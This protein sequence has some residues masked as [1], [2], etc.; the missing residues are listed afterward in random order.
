MAYDKK[1]QGP[2]PGCLI[3][4]IDQSASMEEP[5]GGTQVGGGMKKC[6][7]VA[8]VLNRL[9]NGFILQNTAGGV[10]KSRVDV[11]VLGY[12]ADQIKSALAGSLAGKDFVS[13]PE[14]HDNP[15]GT[16]IIMKKEVDETGNLFEIPINI[17]KWVE[18]I[19]D[20]STP[21]KAA[22][23][24][25]RDLADQWTRNH[26]ESYPPVVINITDG[27]ATDVVD[28]SNPVELFSAAD[29]IKAVQTADGSTLMYTCHLTDR[30]YRSVEFPGSESDLPDDPFA[31]VLYKLTSEVPQSGHVV[32]EN[33]AGTKLPSSARGFIFNGDAGAVVQMFRVGTTAAAVDFRR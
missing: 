25:A 30:T 28:T 32:Y 18:P 8:S 11:A 19:A 4:L 33:L 14:L 21:M 27:M 24:R 17:P 3:I 29:A 10:V 7:M 5:F 2:N 9:L 1:W 26:M 12:G 13:L 16:E 22:F 6:D 20:G 23:D 31:K 15:A